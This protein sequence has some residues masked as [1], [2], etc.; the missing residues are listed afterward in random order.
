[1]NAQIKK[2]DGKLVVQG[3][4]PGSRK[5]AQTLAE[6][7]LEFYGELMA[8]IKAKIYISDRGHNLVYRWTE[9]SN[10]QRSQVPSTVA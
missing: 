1:M 10:S 5:R 8:T 3:K 2:I 6:F 9:P 4:E 7:S